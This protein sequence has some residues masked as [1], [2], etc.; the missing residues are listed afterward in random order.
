V[1]KI[2]IVTYRVKPKWMRRVGHIT[3]D[4]SE[5]FVTILF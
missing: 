1:A 2:N 4:R 3:D 5:K